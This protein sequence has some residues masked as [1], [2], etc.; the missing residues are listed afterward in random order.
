LFLATAVRT[1]V[2]EGPST[3]AELDLLMGFV[4]SDVGVLTVV[5]ATRYEVALRRAQQD[6]DRVLSRDPDFLKRDHDQFERGLSD[7]ACDLAL[8]GAE[9]TPTTLAERVIVTLDGRRAS[10]L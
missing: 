6:P 1:V 9:A 5:L 3:R 2:A 10:P 4:A 7:I 8:D